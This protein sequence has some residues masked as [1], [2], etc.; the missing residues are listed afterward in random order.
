[1]ADRPKTAVVLLNLGGPDGPE[2]VEPFLRNLFSDPAIIGLPNPLR[3]FL[4][5]RIAAKRA[6]IAREIYQEIG[7]GSPILANTEAQARALQAKLDAKF[8]DGV[9]VFIAMRYWRP[10]SEAAAETVKAWGPDRIVLLPL[11]PQYS[12]TTTESSMTDWQRAAKKAGL[13]VQ[14]QLVCCYP[15]QPG[16]IAA[17]AARSKPKIDEARDAGAAKLRVLFSAHGL[18]LRVIARGDPYQ[19]QVEQSAAAIASELGLAEDEWIVCYQSRVGPLKWIGPS[20]DEEITRAGAEGVAVVVVPLS[21]VS[22]HSETLVE[23]DIEYAKLAKEAGVPAYLRVPTV[24]DEASFIDGLAQ[25]VEG[26][27]AA[28][29]PCL[30]GAG[31]RICPG[32]WERCPL[33]LDDSTFVMPVGT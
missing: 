20:T 23:L 22:E 10:R 6:P 29:A 16:F 17:M 25:L 26:A 19:W 8:G 18:P 21:F 32:E 24:D 28:E 7:G 14:T 5:R 13:E 15:R 2:A 4:A 9:R 30:S 27:T 33:V 12:T 31:G 3:S 11:Y 1:V